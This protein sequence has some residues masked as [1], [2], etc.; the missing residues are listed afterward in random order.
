MCS[1]QLLLTLS[2]TD[3]AAWL[4][5]E[6]P[7]LVQLWH[8]GGDDPLAISAKHILEQVVSLCAPSLQNPCV[9]LVAF[10]G[11]KVWHKERDR[12]LQKQKAC[13]H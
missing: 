3:R 12:V 13:R 5:Q 8:S 4:T 11:C 6:A 10:H 2:R 1:E 7:D 9:C